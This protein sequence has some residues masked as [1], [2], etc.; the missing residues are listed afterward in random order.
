MMTDLM[1]QVVD[2]ENMIRSWKRARANKGSPGIDGVTVEDLTGYLRA[3]WP[4][5]RE[6][7]LRGEYRPQPVKEVEIPKTGGG[8][9]RLGIPTVVDRVIQQAIL[10]VLDPIYDPTFSEHSY[11]FRPRRRAHQAVKEAKRHIVEGYEWVVDL[12]LEKFFDRVNHDI[13]MGRLARRIGDKRV[14]RV[15]RRYLQ[16]GVM[17]NG[18]VQERWEGTPQGGPLSPLL[19][20]ILLDELDKELEGRGHRFCRYADDAN[21]SVKSKRAGERVFASIE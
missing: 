18:V 20:N 5:L 4:R 16:A 3:H 7:L 14:L 1:E 8:M 13:L 6:E 21:I 11:G 17:V 10:Q 15:I 2:R 12:D 19:S 9:R